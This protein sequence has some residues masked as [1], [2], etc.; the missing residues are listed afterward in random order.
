MAHGTARPAVCSHRKGKAHAMAYR[1]RY[2]SS[3][4]G[5][6]YARR[7]RGTSRRRAPRSRRRSTGAGRTVRIVIE[8][9]RASS[10]GAIDPET[11]MMMVK[12]SPP[13]RAKF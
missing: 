10:L 2:A 6:S 13:R 8:Q 5:K 1:R 11:G 12:A 4:R 9:P 7:S 3:S